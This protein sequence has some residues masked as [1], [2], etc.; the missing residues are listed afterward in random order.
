MHELVNTRHNLQIDPHLHIWGWEI[1]IY[2]FLGGLVAGMMIIAGYFIMTGRSNKDKSSIGF[3][4]ITAL[5]AISTGMLALFLDL[6]HKL[7]V[8][9]MYTTFQWTAPMSWGA[10]IL[11]LVYPI[12]IL[13]LLVY[14]PD[15]LN[16]SIIRNLKIKISQI[17]GLERLLS[18]L[19]MAVGAGLGVYTGILLSAFVARPA[20]NSAMLWMLFLVSGLSTATA[21][22]HLFG[23]NE[24]EKH[25]LAKVDNALLITELVVIFLL[26]VGLVSS[27]G[28]QASAAMLFLGGSYSVT[29]WVFVVFMGIVIPFILQTAIVKDKIAHSVLVPIFVLAGGLIL[30]FVIVFAGQASHWSTSV[31]K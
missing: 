31:F 10:W 2:L 1:A 27:S 18:Y 9:R 20:W 19:N 6:E 25:F 17:N 30:R 21:Y 28:E 8:W 3:I 22:I 26:L 23:K 4:P 11:L 24:E 12:L 13:T 14:L 5:I 7:F 16:I 15:W 29:F